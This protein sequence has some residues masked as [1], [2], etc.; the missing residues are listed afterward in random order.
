MSVNYRFMIV[1]TTHHYI[2][3]SSSCIFSL[4]FTLS[5]IEQPLSAFPGPGKAPER[6]YHT[7]CFYTL[8]GLFWSLEIGFNV[9]QIKLFPQRSLVKLLLY[10]TGFTLSSLCHCCVREHTVQCLP[11]P[12]ILSLA[13]MMLSSPNSPSV[14][15]IASFLL[16]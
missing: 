12:E 16:P 9:M 7:Q 1:S 2:T 5:A 4:S 13:P 3:F 8:T 15:Q 10:T 14:S 11:L 6:I